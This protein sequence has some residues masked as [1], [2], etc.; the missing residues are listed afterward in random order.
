MFKRI[1]DHDV[2]NVEAILVRDQMILCH[3]CYEGNTTIH[4]LQMKYFSRLVSRGN[5]VV[6]YKA[7]IVP[8]FCYDP[9]KGL[10]VRCGRSGFED[11]DYINISAH[12]P[13]HCIKAFTC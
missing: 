7:L 2:S 6:T 1:N 8:Q 10:T 5:L 12:Q 4:P 13:Q 3:A 9:L 11:S